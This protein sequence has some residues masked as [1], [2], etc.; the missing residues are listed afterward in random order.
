MEVMKMKIRKG[1]KMRAKKNLKKVT[2]GVMGTLITIG[3]LGMNVMA[4]DLS[5]NVGSIG[6]TFGDRDAVICGDTI[7]G[8]VYSSDISGL[9]AISMTFTYDVKAFTDIDVQANNGVTILATEEADNQVTVVFMV[10]PSQ[11][12]YSNLLTIKAV[13]GSEETVGNIKI[14]EFEGAK[15]GELVNADIANDDIQIS[16]L[17]DTL[18][19]EYDV[20][21]LSMAMTFF[22][23]D[24]TSAKW[25]KAARYDMDSND[26]ININDYVKIANLILDSNR[27]GK[28]TFNEDGKFKIMMMSDIQDYVDAQTKQGLNENTVNLMN[29]AL[30]AEKPDVVVITGDQI[31]GNMD[32]DELQDYITQMVEPLE[33]REIPWLI[34]FG[35]HDEDAKSALKDGWNKMKQLSFYRSF[36]YNINRA[37]MSGAQGY[38]SNGVNTHAVGDMYTLIYDQEGKTPLYNIW[39]LD[40]NRYSEIVGGYDWIRQDQIEWYTETSEALEAKYGN[41]INS[42][43]FFHIPTQEWELMYAD[44]EKY[45]VTGEKRE[46]ECPSNVNSGLFAAALERGD[47]KGMF[48][49]HDHVNDYWG[50]YNG[51][52][53]GYDANVGYQTYGDADMRG[54]RIFVLDENNLD[55]FETK[56]LRAADFGVNQ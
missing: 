54:V 30:D 41:K 19:E 29:A 3:T 53:L 18:I 17:S 26:V 44:G 14:T 25:P 33:S 42:L 23:V 38:D 49:G 9:D 1:K 51:I 13:A 35:N 48:V 21:T 5:S 46:A 24:S 32:A 40:S 52:A 4:S 15:Q 36:K 12:D 8:N 39:A 2:A 16:V 10:D 6:L 34:T 55:T 27:I 22:M 47:V 45:G 37:S 20:Q 56:M 50:T 31:G 28:L 7:S 11:A 43:M